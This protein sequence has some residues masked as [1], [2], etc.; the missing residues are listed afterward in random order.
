[1]R[2]S[3]YYSNLDLKK[4]TSS[5]RLAGMWRMT[6]GFRLTYLAAI[7]SLALAALA[8]TLTY[9]IVRNL[10]DKGLAESATTPIYYFALAFLGLAVFEASFTFVAGKMAARTS[11]GIVLRLRNYL[12]DHLQ[13]L[14][15][16][17]HDHAQTGEL[18]QRATSDVDAVRRFFADQGVQLG[19]ISLLFGINFITLLLL[20][21]KLAVQSV[22]FIPLVLVISIVFFKKIEELYGAYQDQ[23]GHLSAALQENLSGV[24][25]V[26]AFAR[27][28]Y[29]IAKFE[30]E[31]YQKYQL[32]KKLLLGHAL[33]WPVT[34]V[35][36]GAQMLL[37]FY[38]G[39]R[40]AIAGE[41][42]VGTYLAFASLV[43]WL[44]WPIRNLG[45]LIAQS[46]T[47]L[48][49]YRR[50]ADLI[51]EKQ[52]VLD[53]G[54]SV[55][56]SG[57][58]GHVVF[59]NVGFAYNPE[60]PAL[61]QV[62]FEAKP[63]EMVAL[64]GSTGSGKTSLVNLLPRFYECT[65]G[66][67]TLDDID[68]K[69]YAKHALRREIGIVEQEPFLFSRNIAENI[70]YGVDRQVSQQEIE[71]AAQA[72]AI[73]NV[74]QTFPEGYKTMVG[75]KGVT[76]SG[77][78]KQRIAIARTL[79]KDPRILILDDSTSSVDTETEMQ[80]Q[81]ALDKLMQGRTT[82]VIAHRVQTVM[83]ADKIVV[84]KDGR[85]AQ[86]GTHSQLLEQPGLYRDI[87]NIQNKV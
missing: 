45:R 79:L 13:R 80:I 61:Q 35:I 21:A 73:H 12:Y 4:T 41:I 8:K 77:G 55:S 62:S 84:L 29:E 22:M 30:G 39:A 23:D 31:N 17:Y 2:N 70:S 85:I 40:M 54:I 53:K 20:N 58:K 10:V 25:V 59:N 49:S 83:K 75:E 26:K 50:V 48:V 27:Q 18:I 42:T 6:E 3:K 43:I 60:S 51:D 74:I 36:C 33:Y 81:S 34:D 14:P 65:G 32:G 63:G 9:L 69:D 78:Q 1:M 28:D 72:A 68:L 19:R 66:Q 76:L 64:M 71:A 46:S 16:T 47:G 57:V 24:R 86:M 52:E 11:E 82:F 87:Y 5:N 67:I 38:L 44:I 7:A 37:S 15:F 56:H